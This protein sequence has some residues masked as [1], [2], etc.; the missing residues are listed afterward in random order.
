M[1][2]EEK[3]RLLNL[4]KAAVARFSLSVDDLNRTRDKTSREEYERLR[5]V[6][7]D[8]WTSAEDARVDLEGHTREHAC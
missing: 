6:S 8:A 1:P 2:C 7:R 3:G 4:Y 5:S